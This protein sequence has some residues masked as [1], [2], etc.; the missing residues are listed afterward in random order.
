MPPARP[1]P[2]ALLYWSLLATTLLAAILAIGTFWLVARSRAEDDWVRHSLAVRNQIDQVL[3]LMQRAEASARGYLLTGDGL[4]L[5][6]Y[7]ESVA[8]LPN[9][10]DEISNLM[11]GMNGKKLADEATRRRPDLKVIFTTGYTPNAVV[12]GG[13]LDPDVHFLA[14][15]FTLEQLASKVRSLLDS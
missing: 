15:P 8:S 6:P 12:H 10:I 7:R 2:L 5:V 3:I 14:K 4:F 1:K 13:V 11:P 9:A